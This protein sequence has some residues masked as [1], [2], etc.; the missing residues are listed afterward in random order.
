MTQPT[1]SLRCM[2]E[3]LS[4]VVRRDLGFEL[5]ATKSAAPFGIF[6]ILFILL[7]LSFFRESCLALNS[8]VS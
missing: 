1:N 4:R 8:E 7:I 2:L 6:G 5:R 3:L